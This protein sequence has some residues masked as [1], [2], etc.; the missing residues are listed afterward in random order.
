MRAFIKS[1]LTS[2]QLQ[3]R[4]ASRY[5]FSNSSSRLD[6]LFNTDMD[7]RPLEGWVLCAKKGCFACLLAGRRD[8]WWLVQPFM[9][10]HPHSYAAVVLLWLKITSWRESVGWQWYQT[11]R[12]ISNARD[13]FKLSPALRNLLRIGFFAGVARTAGAWIS[14]EG[15]HQREN[16]P[17]HL[18]LRCV[19]VCT[20]VVLPVLDRV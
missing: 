8:V 4:E 20:S 3:C 1:V 19:L 16:K 17:L 11:G 5:C 12:E 10:A 13:M 6:Q 7:S 9:A 2:L 14:G 18:C 15:Q